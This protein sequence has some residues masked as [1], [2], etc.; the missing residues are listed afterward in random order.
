MYAPAQ[1]V[2][3]MRLGGVEI[4]R[5]NDL[6]SPT[7][8]VGTAYIDD[9]QTATF[10]VKFK[11]KDGAWSGTDYASG[12][13]GLRLEF[14]NG[15]DLFKP[16]TY[17]D[18]P[19]ATPLPTP[20]SGPEGVIWLYGSGSEGA[21]ANV[22]W[23]TNPD[24]TVTIRATFSKSF[25]DNTYGDNAIG[26]PSGHTF[27]ELW[28][29]DHVRIALVDLE[30]N[31][32]FDA[33]IDF[34]DETTM[35]TGGVTDDH[36]QIYVG[37]AGDVAGVRTSLSENFNTLGCNS[38]TEHSPV[39]DEDYTPPAACPGWDFSVWY[40]ITIESDAFPAG[41]GHPVI[42]TIHASPSKLGINS[43]DVGVGPTPTP[44]ISPTPTPTENICGDC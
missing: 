15:C 5:G 29:S 31:T 12:D 36:G 2:E 18:R 26:W 37:D 6:T 42:T 22:H 4:F 19:T 24:G 43:I 13:F 9:H 20:S 11:D 28:H 17:H 3:K 40:E 34:F 25:V 39:T 32:F 7:N 38:Y 8:N 1:G 10:Y 30:N 23:H 14:D 27:R 35:R 44:L 16:V 21:W 41:F 33:K